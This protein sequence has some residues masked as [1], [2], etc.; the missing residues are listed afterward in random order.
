M[1]V[2]GFCLF[3]LIEN[4]RFISLGLAFWRSKGISCGWIFTSFLP[5]WCY[6]HLQEHQ[7]CLV[8]DAWNNALLCILH[9][10]QSDRMASHL[11]HG[12]SPVQDNTEYLDVEFREA[13]KIQ[14]ASTLPRATRMKVTWWETNSWLVAGRSIIGQVYPSVQLSSKLLWSSML[15]TVRH[16]DWRLRNPM[17]RMICLRC[18]PQI[19]TCAGF[20]IESTVFRKKICGLWSFEACG[21]IS[22]FAH[23]GRVV[24]NDYCH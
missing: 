10:T 4:L 17:R 18:G 15:E 16:F 2:S 11:C 14:E 7:L 9:A 1:T 5:V 23:H 6:F 24:Q 22:F 12:L 3:F 13:R 20:E 21:N 8:Y 19:C